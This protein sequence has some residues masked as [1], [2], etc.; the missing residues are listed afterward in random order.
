MAGQPRRCQGPAANRCPWET[1]LAKE[2][3]REERDKVEPGELLKL[4]FFFCGCCA[5]RPYARHP[6]PFSNAALLSFP[7][8]F[9]CSLPRL[10]SPRRCIDGG[11]VEGE[12]SGGRLEVDGG[13]DQTNAGNCDIYSSPPSLA[14]GRPRQPQPR[15]DQEASPGGGRPRERHL[16]PRG[17]RHRQ[18]AGGARATLQGTLPFFYTSSS[19]SPSSPPLS[20]SYLLRGRLS[21]RPIPRGP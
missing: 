16:R 15:G 12:P 1:W 19:S 14:L 10:G 6:L 5:P 7:R 21:L 18:A 4:V 20:H 13:G 11:V 17:R 9:R 2:R 8:R 3:G